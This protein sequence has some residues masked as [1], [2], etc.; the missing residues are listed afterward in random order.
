MKAYAVKEVYYTLQGEGANAG[1]PAAFVRFS[2]C[3]L[4]SGRDADRG[5]GPGPCSAW[6]DTDFVG[7]GGPNGGR[8]HAAALAAKAAEAWGAG[9]AGRF[10]VLTGGEPM[11][12]VD[13]VLIDALHRFGFEVAVETNGTR[14][15]P[16]S[17]DWITVS[18]KPGTEVVQRRGQELK[19]VHPQDGVDPADFL[20]WSFGRFYLQPLDGRE[21][22]A[23]EAARY[24]LA[25]PPWRLS[26]Q[27]HKLLGLP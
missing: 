14:P 17:V 26:V 8:Y 16:D 2:G 4:W 7:T 1:R 5:N 13:A 20:G 10:A 9:R 15:V 3:N 21:G 25:H 18:P 12:Q 11:L 23:A 22:S 6:C 27:A 19:L 24:C